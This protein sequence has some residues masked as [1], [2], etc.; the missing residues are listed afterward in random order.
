M[1]WFLKRLAENSTR[2]ALL[3][4]LGAGIGVATGSVDANTAI[5]AAMAAFVAFATPNNAAQG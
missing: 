1:K 2:T 5:G 3:T 4:A